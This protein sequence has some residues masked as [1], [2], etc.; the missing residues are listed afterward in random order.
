MNGDCILNKICEQKISH[1]ITLIT[2]NS[3]LTSHQLGR[4]RADKLRNLI[5]INN[6][7][8]RPS[9]CEKCKLVTFPN[10]REPPL[11]PAGV[12]PA[13]RHL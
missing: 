10:V 3:R 11:Q 12:L 13:L 8:Y 7:L 4:A 5:R 2:I 6:S 9:S 1:I